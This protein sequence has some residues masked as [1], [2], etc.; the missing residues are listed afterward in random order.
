MHVAKKVFVFL[1]DSLENANTV[2]KEYDRKGEFNPIGLKL[3][4]K[5][6][7]ASFKFYYTTCMFNWKIIYEKSKHKACKWLLLNL[8]RSCVNKIEKHS[9]V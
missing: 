3:I 4:D 8:L 5:K 9:D 6:G 2:N 7:N 1:Y